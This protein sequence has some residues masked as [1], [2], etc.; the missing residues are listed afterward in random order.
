MKITAIAGESMIEKGKAAG[1]SA[2]NGQRQENMNHNYST[3]SPIHCQH[4]YLLHGKVEGN[5]WHKMASLSKHLL[6]T[7]RAWCVDIHDLDRSESLGARFIE[8]F[9]LENKVTYK[10]SLATLRAKGQ[11]ISRAFGMQLAL[12][13]EYWFVKD[14]V[15]DPGPEQLKLGGAYEQ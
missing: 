12:P 10:A 5:V 6:Q 3:P 1:V 2:P 15:A 7:P 8:I 9:E 14:E 13:L 11:K 4:G